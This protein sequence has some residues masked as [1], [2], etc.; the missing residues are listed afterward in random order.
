MKD[1]N[2]MTDDELLTALGADEVLER[3]RATELKRN[4]AAERKALLRKERRKLPQEYIDA[5]N[6]PVRLAMKEHNDCAVVSVMLATGLPYVE[7]HHAMRKH[8]RPHRRGMYSVHCI[9]A[10]KS[11]GFRLEPVK[12]QEVIKAMPAPA[13]KA[14]HLTTMNIAKHGKDLLPGSYFIFINGHFL[15]VKDGRVLD[16]SHGY[17]RRVKLM[18][19]LVKAS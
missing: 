11:L 19:K 8:G 4:R 15:C 10:I 1:P 3:L 7:V 17:P 16:W 13:N 9:E 12:I 2:D 5:S 18:Y 6:D 14:R